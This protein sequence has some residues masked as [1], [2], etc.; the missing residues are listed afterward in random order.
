MDNAIM[1]RNQ[2]QACIDTTVPAEKPNEEN[3]TGQH[4]WIGMKSSTLHAPA[5]ITLLLC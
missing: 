3:G 4:Y 2:R 5:L 1:A